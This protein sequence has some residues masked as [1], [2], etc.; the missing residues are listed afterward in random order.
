MI[1]QQ[2]KITNNWIVHTY[3]LTNIAIFI[4]GPV[5]ISTYNRFNVIGIMLPETFPF[6]C[7]GGNS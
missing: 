2:N 6:P 1:F 4:H 7:L 3:F 5:I